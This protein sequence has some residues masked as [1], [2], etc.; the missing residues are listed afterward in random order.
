MPLPGREPRDTHFSKTRRDVNTD[1]PRKQPLN[2]TSLLSA[3]SSQGGFPTANAISWP[4]KGPMALPCPG[5]PRGASEQHRMRG[6]CERGPGLGLPA[7]DLPKA[8]SACGTTRWTGRA[9]VPVLL[10]TLGRWGLWTGNHAQREG[11]LT[12][13]LSRRTSCSCREGPCSP[14]C[15]PAHSTVALGASLHLAAGD[16]LRIP[17]L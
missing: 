2:D 12:L 13:T 14:G 17:R 7:S 15:C 10:R 9:G 4:L 16:R 3:A 8:G 1:L 5:H 11:P 6:V